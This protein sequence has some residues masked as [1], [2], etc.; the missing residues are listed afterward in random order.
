MKRRRPASS[1]SLILLALVAT[2]PVACSTN[3]NDNPPID[4][5]DV[6]GSDARA[7]SIADSVMLAMGGR[8]NWDKTR[9]LSWTFGSDDQVWDKWSGDLRFQ[10]DSLVV[11]MNVN[12]RNGRAWAAGEEVVDE[13]ALREI[14]DRAYRAWVNSG[15]WFLM[16]Y[17][18]K[19]SGVT[20]TYVG[21]GPMQDGTP[22][23]ILHLTFKEVGLTPQNMYDVYVDKESKLVG[24]W[25]HYSNQ[26]DAEP[27]FTRPWGNWKRYG[28]IMLSDYRG[29]GGNGRP[30]VIGNIGAYDTLPASVFD[31][32]APIDVSELSQNQG[33]A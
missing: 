28:K 26:T 11:L 8:A 12:D 3:S 25:S 21:D 24:Q 6:A 30:F 4:G 20:L 15:Y 13:T 22:A 1:R 23:H 9:Y 16:P 5:F 17:K 2:L 32:P 33:A 18:L 14:L 19:D 29:E 10:R 31:D 27:R 7:V